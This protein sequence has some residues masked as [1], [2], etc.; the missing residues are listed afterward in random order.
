MTATAQRNRVIDA[1]PEEV[2]QTLADFGKIS[3]WAPNVSH[4]ATLSPTTEGPGTAR[5]VQAGRNVLVETVI[6]WEP[7]SFLRYRIEGLPRRLGEITNEWR[8]EPTT[9]A[10]GEPATSVTLTSTV[11]TGP[12]PPQRLIERIVTRP[13]AKASQKMLD[14]LAA[15]LAPTTG[16]TR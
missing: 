10:T 8:L 6:D 16:A 1:A 11:N 12:R 15:H 5:R 9:G 2:W 14:G 4:S 7:P 13:L 3:R